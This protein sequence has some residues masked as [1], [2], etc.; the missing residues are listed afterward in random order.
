MYNLKEKTALVIDNGMYFE[1]ARSLA[2]SF[3]KV[4]YF[5]EYHSAYPG[6]DKA[7][8]GNEY[9]QGHALHS[10]DD[11]PVCR[12][13]ELWDVI[14]SVDIAVFPDVGNGDLAEYLRKQGIPVFGAG[15]GE[16]LELGRVKAK[17]MIAEE[18]L[19]VDPYEMVIGTTALREALKEPGSCYIKISKYRGVFET[20]HHT[21]PE[22]TGIWIDDIEWRLGKLAD[23]VHFIIEQP[24]ETEVEIGT[25]SYTVA[26]QYPSRILAGTEIKDL[27]YCGRFFSYDEQPQGIRTVDA[28]LAPVFKKL[29]YRGWYSTEIRETKD[30][31]PYLVDFTART[32]T[33]PGFLYPLLYDNYADIVWGVANGEMVEPEILHQ[34]GMMV[35]LSSPWYVQHMLH[36]CF[37]EEYREHVQLLMP[38]K[39]DGEYY[40][41]SEYGMAEFGAVSVVG[42]SIEECTAKAEEIL[43]TIEAYQFTYDANVAEKATNAFR[44]MTGEL[45][46]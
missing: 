32:P 33:P 15:C 27:G 9:R 19:A 10:F 34:Y 3:G 7:A 18:G 31:T 14:D 17:A 28:G 24:L 36:V 1:T 26:G 45:V 30:G 22:Q 38:V 37:P 43:Q 41:I 4:Y 21:K 2:K 44:T 46:A 16:V 6:I 25:D 20:F 12:I 11:L 23:V 39:I 40:C 5:C 35:I 8:I 29:D 42:D 13:T